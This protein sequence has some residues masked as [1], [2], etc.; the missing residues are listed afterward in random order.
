MKEHQ[1]LFNAQ[2]VRAILDGRKTQTRRVM[3]P[4][5]DSTH[6][7]EPYWFI[8]GYRAWRFTGTTAIL[9]I[10]SFNPIS[11][12][13]GKT[14]DRLW[15]RESWRIGAWDEDSGCVAIDYMADGYCRKEWIKPTNDPRGEIFARLWL[16]SANDA[17]KVYGELDQYDWQAGESPCRW[18]PSIHMPRWASR[19]LLEVTEVR[20]ERLQEISIQDAM[21][22]GVAETAPRLKDLEPCM[23]WR[24]AYE[25]L[26]NVIN[27]PGSWDANPWVW[28][29]E[30]RRIDDNSKG[31]A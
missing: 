15:V 19:I 20:V 17:R 26:W 16:Q 22:E 4:Q 3:K 6:D 1:I 27:G 24:Y 10:G 9:R 21:A 13:Y 31:M 30:F 23:E 11:S 8:G 2:M 25:D 12:P 28:V 14:G 29:I 7:G 18:R 5:P